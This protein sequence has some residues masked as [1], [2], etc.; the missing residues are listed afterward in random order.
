[1]NGAQMIR[2]YAAV[3]GVIKKKEAREALGMDEE[4]VSRSFRTL[5][6]QGSLEVV[7]RGIYR[8]IER[9]DKPVA[10]TT[11]KIWRAMRMSQAFSANEIAMLSGTSTA[12]VY[13][14]FHVYKADGYIKP[15]GIRTTGTTGRI[16]LWRLTRKG[17]NKAQNTSTEVYI[18][19]SLVVA[20]VHLNRLVCSG[21]VI[22]D[23]SAA[24]QACDIAD[25]IKEAIQA[26]DMESS[27]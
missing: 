2:N 22:R 5:V 4:L 27:E 16:K 13:K 11:D 14:R 20:A 18:P 23:K 24:D 8:F 9:I 15:A 25:A 6:R 21:L 3:N 1:M 7:E 17:K 26:L 10:E 12:Y 19:D